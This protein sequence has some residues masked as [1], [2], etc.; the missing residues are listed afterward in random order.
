MPNTDIISAIT[1]GSTT[2]E[3][4]DN[5][6]LTK[7]SNTTAKNQMYVKDTSGYQIMVD[8]PVANSTGKDSV[9]NTTTDDN[10]SRANIAGGAYSVAF[11]SRNVIG[12]S[13]SESGAF[14]GDIHINAENT[15]GFGYHVW[16]HSNQNLIGGYDVGSNAKESLIYGNNIGVDC[17]HN[18]STH[19]WTA[20]STADA[21]KSKYLM[22]FGNNHSIASNCQADLVYGTSITLP[23][24]VYHSTIGGNGIVVH[25]ALDN[26]FV[27]GQQHHLGSNSSNWI[28]VF[29]YN[30]KIGLADPTGSSDSYSGGNED[31]NVFGYQNRVGAYLTDSTV[32]G[33]Y[34]TISGGSGVSSKNES[35]YAIG[36]SN[37]NKPS[38]TVYQ[39]VFMI[40]AYLRAEAN[41]RVIVGRYNDGTGID[42]AFFEVGCGSSDTSRRTGFAV[43]YNS[44]YGGYFAYLGPT[45]LGGTSGGLTVNGTTVSLSG[46]THS[47]GDITSGTFSTSRIPNLSA[48]KITSG[49]FDTA[50]IPSLA[51]SKITSGTFDAARIPDLSSTYSVVGHNHDGSYV[52]KNTAITGATKCKVTYDSKGLVTAGSD[53]TATD[54]PSL[55]ADKIT[56]GTF[57][58][59]RIPT[60]DSTSTSSDLVVKCNDSRLSNSR[61]ASDVYAW[62]K[63]STKP[64]YNFSEISDKYQALLSWGGPDISGGVS[65]LEVGIIDDL[66]HNK[67]AFMSAAGVVIQYSRDGGS[68]WS[69][70]GATDNE[71]K[72]LV[73]LSGYFSIGKRTG[74]SNTINDKLRIILNSNAAG[75]NVYT[76]LRRLLF[77]VSTNGSTGCTVKIETRTIG[78]YK[79][80]VD[81]WADNGTH[82]VQG[83]SGWNSP[84]FSCTFGGSSDQTSQIAQI[85]LTFGVTAVSTTSSNFALLS[86]RAIGFPLWSSPSTMASNGH[87]YSFDI[88]QN[89]TFPASV[90][91]TTFSENGT[92]LANKYL[93]KSATASDSSKL[94]GQAA[95]YYAKATDIPSAYIKSASTSG[96]TLTLTKQDNTTVV[97]TPSFT[98]TNQKIKAG[99]VT[100]GNNDVVNIVAGDNVTITGLASGTGAPKITISAT[101][102]WRPVGTGST[103]AAAGNHVHGNIN[104][105]GTITSTVVTSAT[106]VLVYD[107]NNKIQRA[108]AAST[109]SIIGA[110]T[111]SK[112]SGGIPDS[113]IASAS[114]WNGKYSKPSG[115]IPATDLAE[116]YYLS[117]N[118]NGYTSNTGTVIGSS[119][120]ADYLILGNGTVNVKV[121]SYKPSSSSTTW[122]TSSDV[123]LPTMKAISSYV[124]GLGYTTNTGTVI[125]SD[126]TADR[127]VLGNGTVNVKKSTYAPGPSSTTWSDS[128]DVY[129]PTMKAVSNYVSGKS[130]IYNASATGD[131]LTVTKTTD[132]H[133]RDVL[134][135][136]LDDDYISGGSVSSSNKL[137]TEGALPTAYLKSASVSGNTLTL[138]KQD[139][140][141]VTYTPSFTDKYHTSGSWNG[142]TYT[143]TAN[144]GAGALA[145][146]I[147]TGTTS[148]TV[149]AGNHTHTLSLAADSGTS[150]I[151]LQ[152]NTK[153]KL[154]AG[155]ST[156]V[157]KTPAGGGGSTLYRHN[158]EMVIKTGSSSSGYQYYHC[159]FYTINSSSTAITH[160]VFYGSRG[161]NYIKYSLQGGY[162]DDNSE[163]GYYG[164]SMNWLPRYSY[165]NGYLAEL[166]IS[167]RDIYNGH[168]ETYISASSAYSFTDTVETLS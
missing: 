153:Y 100:F 96:N 29:G 162:V 145:F 128:S 52:A 101:D 25:G 13:A 59:A 19:T 74:S 3:I 89:A 82:P 60:G 36:Y 126:L 51:A 160:S 23:Q 5:T 155:G 93:G 122:S 15:Y 54:I 49:T 148:T 130:Y 10:I 18:A 110:G 157:F 70:Y 125:G 88:S 4:R 91:A 107:S 43:G 168:D 133:D 67:F 161:E 6:K 108:T 143:A 66:G 56:S 87:L 135:I 163:G 41:D 116:S 119:L 103:D 109:R 102:T 151:D 154:T 47:A 40:G 45:R 55:S 48:S 81:T 92:T 146:T 63:A 94:N 69:D 11:G 84:S 123:Y 78:N 141:T 147:Q 166:L 159:Y 111:Y 53:L 72:S 30:N 150:T 12:S 124:T 142:L 140:G 80:N 61:P 167:V 99:D 113:D 105:A 20:N 57:A 24:Y 117:S 158:I 95:S 32:I 34:N 75:G 1:V 9:I 114:T 83:W 8:M 22:V 131:G 137:V 71:K 156:L 139:N 21:N 31:I 118:P 42:G 2:Y 165:R 28:N 27:V 79:N 115:G 39:R 132:L 164:L 97:Y 38:S 90:S 68:T 7:S 152:S 144:G 16:A 136:G 85:R 62:A 73:T 37:N 86:I 35:V 50:R 120:T 127:F 112:P 77:N 76:N 17:T 26:S 46:H 64:S 134:E 65:P 121:S 104:N 149:A 33:Y 98:D 106:G 44:N 58:I 129:L 138:T 14:G